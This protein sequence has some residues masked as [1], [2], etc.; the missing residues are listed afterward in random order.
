MD[1]N[2]K[3]LTP[4]E[5]KV[6]EAIASRKPGETDQEIADSIGIARITLHRIRKS[7]RFRAA[8]HERLGSDQREAILPVFR[9]LVECAASG[10]MQA[11]KLFWMLLGFKDNPTVNVLG[12]FGQNN[13]GAAPQETTIDVEKLEPS[14][15]AALWSIVQKIGRPVNGINESNGSSNP[16]RDTTAVYDLGRDYFKSLPSPE[17][18]SLDIVR[19]TPVEERTVKTKSTPPNLS[20]IPDEKVN[21]PSGPSV[22]PLRVEY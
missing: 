3:P 18:D 22:K 21:E 5:L 13:S 6:F 8:I 15:R 1:N 19:N 4:V 12:L 16:A 7:D 10:D 20:L 14:E 11:Q 2:N 9:K 17:V